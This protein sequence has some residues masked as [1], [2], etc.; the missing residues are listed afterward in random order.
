MGHLL[1]SK[2][3][4]VSNSNGSMS[5]SGTPPPN[6]VRNVAPQDRSARR[7]GMHREQLEKSRLRDRKEGFQRYDG[8]ADTRQERHSLGFITEADRFVTD[9]AAEEKLTRDADRAQRE[10][11]YYH[12]R[13][14]RSE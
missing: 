3:A 5:S 2:P 13:V 10:L 12:K 9:T 6:G 7:A 11:K 14:N 8:G 1:L 4:I